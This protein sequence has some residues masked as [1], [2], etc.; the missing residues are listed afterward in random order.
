MEI[1]QEVRNDEEMGIVKANNRVDSSIYNDLLNCGKTGD[2]GPQ[3][4]KRKPIK[5]QFLRK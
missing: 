4:K 3:F 5:L 2:G 1:T